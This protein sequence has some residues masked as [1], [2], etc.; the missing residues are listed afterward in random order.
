[1]LPELECSDHSVPERDSGP[2]AL[3]TFRYRSSV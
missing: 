1:M 2:A 3:D